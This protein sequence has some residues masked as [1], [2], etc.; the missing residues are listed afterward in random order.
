MVWSCAR[1]GL[2][3][4]GLCRLMMPHLPGADDEDEAEYGDEY[5]FGNDTNEGAADQRAGDRSGGHGEYE[6]PV[7]GENGET[8][9]LAV[10]A[11][12]NDHRR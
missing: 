12:R 9:V 4:C 2:L 3:G 6:P 1:S 8:R 7:Y 5:C 10:T 11:E